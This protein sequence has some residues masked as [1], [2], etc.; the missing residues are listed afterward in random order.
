MF[1][2]FV[3]IRFYLYFNLFLALSKIY[4]NS[5]YESEKNAGNKINFGFMFFFLNQMRT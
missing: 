3:L 5:N 4:N 2:N 1:E